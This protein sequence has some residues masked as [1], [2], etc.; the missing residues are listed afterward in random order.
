M[1][2]ITLATLSLIFLTPSSPWAFKGYD[3]GASVGT[4]RVVFK[5]G[6]VTS[7]SAP[8]NLFELRRIWGEREI[9]RENQRD[10]VIRHPPTKLRQRIRF[11]PTGAK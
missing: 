6:R 1:R 11:E 3:D 5:D 10:L 8:A 7:V 9:E 2:T 4:I